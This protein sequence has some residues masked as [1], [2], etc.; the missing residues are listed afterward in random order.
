[1][2]QLE[3]YFTR[4]KAE[5]ENGADINDAKASYLQDFLDMYYACIYDVERKF[6]QDIYDELPFSQVLTLPLAERE[7]DILG[8]LEWFRKN[9]ADFNVGEDEDVPLMRSVGNV[10]A[11]MTEY[12]IS[13]G[14]NPNIDEDDGY[15]KANTFLVSLDVALLNESFVNQ[16]DK[17]LFDAVLRTA[18][19]LA[20]SGVIG[21]LHCIK[22]D[23]KNRTVSINS[24]SVLF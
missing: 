16:P 23:E 12:L 4:I 20:R 8:A 15:F 1:M 11:Y 24:A 19:V 7:W 5:V 18:V 9:G 17:A 6:D 22:I 2:L 13:Y 14:A 21:R 3:Q 10:D